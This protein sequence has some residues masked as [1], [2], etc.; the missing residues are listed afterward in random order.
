MPRHNKHEMPKVLNHRSNEFRRTKH[1]HREH[2]FAEMWK[3]ENE[4]I[5][6]INNGHGI[7]Q[8]LFIERGSWSQRWIT[9]IISNRD[10]MIAATVVQWLGTN[11]GMDFLRR[12]LQRCGYKLVRDR[13]WDNH[14]D[15]CGVC[16]GRFKY[17]MKG[18]RHVCGW[19]GSD[20]PKQR[21]R[22]A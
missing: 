9:K 20:M 15:T 16:C 12:T 8:D 6:W 7:L 21:L 2:A 17:G 22:A 4:P 14:P 10:A 5:R 11:C 19:C 3:A 1:S 18:G 13:E